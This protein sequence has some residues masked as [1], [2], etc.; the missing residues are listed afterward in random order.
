MLEEEKTEPF[1]EINRILESLKKKDVSLA[2]HWAREHRDFL[3]S[4]VCARE[5]VETIR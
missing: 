1:S 2:L 5:Y 4:Q 3:A